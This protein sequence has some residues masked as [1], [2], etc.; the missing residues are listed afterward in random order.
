[1]RK[2]LFLILLL[3]GLFGNPK[4]FAQS[5]PFIGQIIPVAFNFAPVGWAVCNG[6]LLSIAQNTALFSLLGTQYG[7]NGFST[8]G[9]PD[10]RGR[11]IVGEGIGPGLIPVDQGELGGS[12]QVQLILSNIP[13][14]S[15]SI[16]AN[17][18]AG[19]TSVPTNNVLANTS[20]SDKEYSSSSDTSM[21]ATGSAGSNTPIST[22]QPYTGMNYI[23]AT[24][25]IYP[26][27]R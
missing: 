5:E 26:A 18:G 22:M 16:G 13:S 6:Q 2:K 1:M 9:L 8:F 24:Q 3:L 20:G 10:L 27:R 15:H 7:G 14:H 19:T 17:T 12:S 11:V 23:I 21:S 4:T 25:G